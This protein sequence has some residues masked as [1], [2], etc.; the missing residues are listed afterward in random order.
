MSWLYKDWNKISRIRSPIYPELYKHASCPKVNLHCGSKE[1]ASG[2]LPYPR[3]KYMTSADKREPK[4]RPL[5]RTQL[6][7]S[8]TPIPL[9]P[10]PH[11]RS[12]NT[13]EG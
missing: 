3:K 11:L 8:I 5:S 1:L 13:K 7:L 4:Q 6:S 10:H 9:P 2:L 12:E